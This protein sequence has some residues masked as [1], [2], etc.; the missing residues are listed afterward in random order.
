M[1]RMY[2]HY[3][4]KNVKSLG[5]AVNKFYLRDMIQWQVIHVVCQSV[6]YLSFLMTIQIYG[7]KL[8]FDRNTLR[9]SVHHV[10]TNVGSILAARVGHQ[11]PSTY[12]KTFM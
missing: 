2:Y 7:T 11:P 9:M 12:R 6:K 4:V 1:Y 8:R 5:L 3:G 10:P